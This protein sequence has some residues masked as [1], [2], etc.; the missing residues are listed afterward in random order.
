MEEDALAIS[1]EGRT[2]RSRE[3]S[4]EVDVEEEVDNIVVVA[5]HP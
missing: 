2:Q 5:A 1:T 3:E 4:K